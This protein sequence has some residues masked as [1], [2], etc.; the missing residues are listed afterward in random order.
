M[1]C[2]PKLSARYLKVILWAFPKE[3]DVN[4][5]ESLFAYRRLAR[6]WRPLVY[7]SDDTA[8]PCS[9]WGASNCVLP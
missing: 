2:Y 9:I 8:A 6:H 4:P 7:G 3:S 1:Y 5:A